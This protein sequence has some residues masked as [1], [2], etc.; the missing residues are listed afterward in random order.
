MHEKDDQ[1]DALR[2]AMQAEEGSAIGTWTNAVS[3]PQLGPSPLVKGMSTQ[4]LNAIKDQ[5]I[6]RDEWRK[7]IYGDAGHMTEGQG[8]T[9]PAP[10]LS[11][12]TASTIM[13]AYSKQYVIGNITLSEV[14][15]PEEV[16]EEMTEEEKAAFLK[17][18]GL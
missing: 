6:S 11:S 9:M 1:Y 13:P 2:H 17:R 8:Y 5:L 12:I 7:L 16:K 14:A 4:F 3:E 10:N 18:L 15:P